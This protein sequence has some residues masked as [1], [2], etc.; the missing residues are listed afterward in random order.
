MHRI[1]Q[2]GKGHLGAAPLLLQ[3]PLQPAACQHCGLSLKLT[4]ES[5]AHARADRL[6]D[7]QPCK[8]PRQQQRV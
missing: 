2:R 4:M 6:P 8:Q 7:L 3:T 5:I 1:A